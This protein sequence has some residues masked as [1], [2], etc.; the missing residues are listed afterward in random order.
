MLHRRALSCNLYMPHCSCSYFSR[1]QSRIGL[2]QSTKQKTTTFSTLANE[3]SVS[4]RKWGASGGV[5]LPSRLLRTCITSKIAASSSGHSQSGGTGRLQPKV[6]ATCLTGKL[7]PFTGHTPRWKMGR[8]RRRPGLTHCSASR[9]RDPLGSSHVLHLLQLPL[10][11]SLGHFPV[12]LAPSLPHIRASVFQPVRLEHPLVPHSALLCP[13]G[14]RFPQPVRNR[15]L[16]PWTPKREL[17]C[18]YIWACST[19]IGCSSQPLFDWL[20]AAQPTQDCF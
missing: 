15:V 20:S 17:P 6:L 5:L 19:L 16:S 18:L 7:E 8:G 11:V 1:S 9:P 2:K 14:W 3:K 12:A 4:D 13:G 10:S